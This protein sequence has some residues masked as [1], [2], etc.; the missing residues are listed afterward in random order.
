MTEAGISSACE[1]SGRIPWC[2]PR[3]HPRV[4][5]RCLRRG[6]PDR[7]ADVHT[8]H[9]EDTRMSPQ[10]F[11]VP[12]ILENHT[13]HPGARLVSSLTPGTTADRPGIPR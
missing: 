2:I 9:V 4:H 12:T 7:G 6:R 3:V 10:F 13:T 8:D 5:A 11:D 1:S